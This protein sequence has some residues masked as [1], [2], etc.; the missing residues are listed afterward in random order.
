M[1]KLIRVE[2]QKCE[3]NFYCNNFLSGLRDKRAKFAVEYF[4]EPC[5]IE[6]AVHN[7]VTYMEAHQAPSTDSGRTTDRLSKSVRFYADT[8]SDA[9]NDDSSDNEESLTHSS[10]SF[11][12][13]NGRREKQI[14]SIRKIK[15]AAS[16]S[17]T[18]STCNTN[19]SLSQ[20]EIDFIHCLVAS[21]E[22]ETNR[23]QTNRKL[24]HGHRVKRSSRVK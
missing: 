15:T 23:R 24:H 2:T 21:A 19:D 7:V 3:G 5:T 10:R 17:E 20:K 9:D 14:Q 1:T 22:R 13:S 18:K 11:S 6:D 4:K 16:T 12:P 8:A